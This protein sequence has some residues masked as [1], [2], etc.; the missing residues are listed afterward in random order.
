MSKTERRL[1][2]TLDPSTGFPAVPAGY[3]W[4]VE[5]NPHSRLLNDIIGVSLWRTDRK[6]TFFRKKPYERHT[7][8]EWRWYPSNDASPQEGLVW[9][10]RG[11]WQD[12][13]DRSDSQNLLGEYPPNSI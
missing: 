1:Q 4:K 9:T 10:A 2:L 5:R 13:L 12:E 3:Y 8:V 11:I 6:V 7:R